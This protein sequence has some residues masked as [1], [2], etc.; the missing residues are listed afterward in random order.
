MP[1]NGRNRSTKSGADPQPGTDSSA[2]INE[3]TQTINDLEKND[4]DRVRKVLAKLR[5]LFPEHFDFSTVGDEVIKNILRVFNF[6]TNGKTN[7]LVK[8]LKQIIVSG[9]CISCYLFRLLS[10]AS[11]S[12]RKMLL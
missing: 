1:S 3:I 2:E 5:E 11:S 9:V 8:K 7:T 4:P 12:D 10:L 6:D